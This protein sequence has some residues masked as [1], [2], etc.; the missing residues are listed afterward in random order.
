MLAG[1][2][3]ACVAP[4]RFPLALQPPGQSSCCTYCKASQIPSACDDV[5]M[6]VLKPRHPPTQTNIMLVLLRCGAGGPETLQP[7]Q[8]FSLAG[9]SGP[10]DAPS[11]GQCSSVL[12]A[13]SLAL[14]FFWW[15]RC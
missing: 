2:A 6:H 4:F 8:S 9:I 10:S 3:P 12:R 5:G 13:D 1:A 15:K 7:K 14:S 11:E